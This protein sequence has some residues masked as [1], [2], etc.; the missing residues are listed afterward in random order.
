MRLFSVIF[1][2]R[3]RREKYRYK[4]GKTSG[5]L[6]PHRI[7]IAQRPKS[8]EKKT[9]FGDPEADT[10]IGAHHQRAIVS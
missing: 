4:G 10:L 8:V 6:I 3:G 5:R 1:L 9:K 2:L 7:D